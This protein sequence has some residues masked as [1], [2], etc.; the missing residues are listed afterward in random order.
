M[1]G[2]WFEE[3]TVGTTVEHATRRTV[4]ETDNVLFTTM[5]MNPAPLHLDADYASRTEFGRPLVNSMFTAALVVGLS[6]PELTLGTIVAQLGLSEVTFPAPVFTGDTIKVTT[7]IVE[8]RASRSRPNAGLV[9]FEHR[10]TNQ[11]D[12]LVCLARRTGLM[13]RRPTPTKEDR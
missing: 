8:A 5:T 13:L 3:L 9:V 10:A 12:E 6:V 11:R 7:E 2:M 4:T 1:T